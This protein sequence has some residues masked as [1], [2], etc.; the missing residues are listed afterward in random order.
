MEPVQ[1]TSR[2]F[3]VSY[4]IVAAMIILLFGLAVL[5]GIIESEDTLGAIVFVTYLTSVFI[6]PP[7]LVAFLALN[8]WGAVKYPRHRLRYVVI[9]VSLAVLLVWSVYGYYTV[10]LP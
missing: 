8:L 4:K 3:S 6:A 1:K 9:S 7:L 2:K 5:R 10:Q